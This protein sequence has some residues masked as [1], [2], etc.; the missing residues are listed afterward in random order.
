MGEE[1]LDSPP[2]SNHNKLSA[3]GRG[4]FRREE[5][6]YATWGKRG[7]IILNGSQGGGEKSS[8]S[9]KGPHSADKTI[10]RFDEPWFH[11]GQHHQISIGR[12]KS[13]RK[14]G[15]SE[16]KKNAGPNGTSRGLLE[17]GEGGFRENCVNLGGG[18]R[19]TYLL[20]SDFTFQARGGGGGAPK[21]CHGKV[22]AAFNPRALTA[23]K[24]VKRSQEA[25]KQTSRKGGSGRIKWRKR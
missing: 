14:N 10:S 9:G 23:Q 8:S 15:N 1:G 16:K 2:N 12:F 25:T 6:N 17:P 19:G 20:G 11:N 5:K 13:T 22:K 21:G 4:E 24:A 18:G 7:T 3:K